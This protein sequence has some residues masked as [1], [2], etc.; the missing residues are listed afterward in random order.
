MGSGSASEP[1][2]E[3]AIVSTFSPPLRM[4]ALR[5]GGWASRDIKPLPC[6]LLA[7]PCGAVAP[8]LGTTL[9]DKHSVAEKQKLI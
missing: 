7:A 2:G 1:R 9:L 5:K 4:L 6:L 3:K 8:S